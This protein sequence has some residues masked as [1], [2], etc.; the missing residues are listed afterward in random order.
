MAKLITELFG[1]RVPIVQGGMS[2]VSRS[3][4]VTAVGE[5]G[6]LGIIGSGGME[7]DELREEIRAV[8]TGTDAPFG[9]NLPL[10]NVRPDGD[11][12]IVEKLLAVILEERV[13]IVVTGAGSPKRF[14]PALRDAGCMVMHVVPSVELAR[15]AEAAG[16][17]V[18]VAESSEAGGHVRSGGLGT[19]TLLPQ[20]VDNVSVPVIAAGGIADPRGFAAALALGASGIQLGT[21]FVATVECNAHSRYKSAIVDA[22]AE[23][24]P[25]YC[26]DYHASRGLA[27]PAIDRLIEMEEQGASLDEIKSFRGRGRARAGCIDGDLEEGIL[28]AGA[29]VGM[30]RKL[31]TVAEVIA[32]FEESI[33]DSVAE[34]HSALRRPVWPQLVPARRCS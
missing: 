4:L 23:G 25:I 29:S 19:F 5:A 34:L 14:T 20:V 1:I 31:Q 26:R 7:P 28:P 21:R 17:D 27:T 10:I 24:A 22:G 18:I 15:K 11:N 2:W 16:V 12:S 32:D 3:G 30:V 8:R 9:V 33:R 13:P 6:G